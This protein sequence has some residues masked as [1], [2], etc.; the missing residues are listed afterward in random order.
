[1]RNNSLRKEG[2]VFGRSNTFCSLFPRRLA[3][4]KNVE[5]DEDEEEEEEEEEEEGRRRG[6]GGGVSTRPVHF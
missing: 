5:E 3:P 1:M 4:K 2:I 6:V